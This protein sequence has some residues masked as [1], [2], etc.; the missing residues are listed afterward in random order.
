M[1]L[2]ER[3]LPLRGSKACYPSSWV[4]KKVNQSIGRSQWGRK[5]GQ[6][7]LLRQQDGCE[8]WDF[9]RTCTSSKQ[10]FHLGVDLIDGLPLFAHKIIFSFS[11]NLC[12][13]AACANDASIAT[14]SATMAQRTFIAVMRFLLCRIQELLVLVMPYCFSCGKI[15]SNEVK[16]A[17]F[18]FNT[19][20]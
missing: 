14:R 8:K 16:R 9:F 19:E 15:F 2:I 7:Q 10:D 13:F 20:I 18:L 17:Q 12:C 11:L 3:K 5:T 1:G 6:L 4:G